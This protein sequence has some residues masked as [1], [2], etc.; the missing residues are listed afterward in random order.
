MANTYLHTLQ[1]LGRVEATTHMT[2]QEPSFKQYQDD[3]GV[4]L[5]KLGVNVGV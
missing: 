1:S 5:A 2:V 4:I 3:P